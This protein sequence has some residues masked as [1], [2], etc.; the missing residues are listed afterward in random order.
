M[1]N[2]VTVDRGFT[3]LHRSHVIEGKVKHSSIKTHSHGQ[4]LISKVS[5]ELL[6]SYG[7]NDI[8]FVVNSTLVCKS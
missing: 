1:K 4:R 6:C 5:P 8:V 3:E 2:V 7:P